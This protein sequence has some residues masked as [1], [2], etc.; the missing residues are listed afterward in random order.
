[1]EDPHAGGELLEEAVGEPGK[2]VILLHGR[3]ASAGSILD[4]GRSVCG[5]ALLLAPAAENRAWYPEPFMAPREDNQPWLDAALGRVGAVMDTAGER[6]FGEEDAHLLGFSQGACLAADYAARNPGRYG[7]VYALSGGLI[8]ADLDGL[9]G[10]LERT[11]VFIG[12]SDED[13]Y[14]PLERVEETAQAFERLNADVDKRVYR[15]MGHTVNAEEK[16]VL[17]ERLG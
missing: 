6:G 12:C 16:A 11:P 2:A 8:G 15:G 7:G 5:N 9:E 1:M 10:D 3:G 4:L 17:R 14:I 13:P